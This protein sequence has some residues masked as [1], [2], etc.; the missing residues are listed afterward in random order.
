MHQKNQTCD[1][2][3]RDPFL[4]ITGG[5][6]LLYKRIWDF[7]EILK[8]KEVHFGLLG[9]PFHLDYDV[10]KRLEDLGCIKR[11][12]LADVIMSLP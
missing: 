8:E 5:D 2:L 6:P 1:K 4:V 10:V 12:R 3:E 7:L 9:N 11:T